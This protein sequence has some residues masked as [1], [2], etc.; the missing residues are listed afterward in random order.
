MAVIQE[1]PEKKPK[2]WLEKPVF[3]VEKA[4]H[5]LLETGGKIT[6][7][8]AHHSGGSAAGK[9]RPAPQ[10]QARIPSAPAMSHRGQTSYLNLSSQ[11]ERL[12]LAQD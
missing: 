5:G 12:R 7:L 10:S 3:L 1:S 2:R 4:Q 11:P 8:A 6:E 9:G